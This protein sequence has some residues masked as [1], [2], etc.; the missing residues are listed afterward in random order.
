MTLALVDWLIIISYLILSVAIGLFYTRKAGKNS[1]SFFL[2]GRN[3]PWW[4]AG[5]SMVA[6]TFAA[7]TP[8]AVT[9]LVGKNGISGNWLWWS[10]LTGGMLTVFFFARLWRRANILTEVEFIELR[11]SGKE[12]S[13][14]R[15]FKG[16]Y[17][18]LIMNVVIL[19]WV[20]LAMVKI[21]MVFF[22][23]DKTTALYYTAGLMMF[24]A[25]YSSLS[26]LLGVAMTDV[27]QFIIAMTG[28][29][30]LAVIVVNSDKIGGIEGLKQKLPNDLLGFFPSTKSAE[31]SGTNIPQTFALSIG[32]FLAFF[33]VQW[34]SSWYPGAEPGGGGYVAQR[35]MSTKTEKDSI[36]A[37]LF[38]Q[39]TH[40]CLRPWPWILVGL[41]SLVLYPD[42]SM[43]DKGQ[44]FVMAMKE[45]LP[46][47]LKGFLLVAFLAAYMS[48][49]STQLNWGTSYIVNDVYRRF[50]RKQTSFSSNEKA[51]KHYVK[52]GRIMTMVLMIISL[53]VTT[54]L[55][56]IS[57]AWEFVMECGAGLGGVLIVRWYWWRVNAWSEIAATFSPFIYYTVSKYL[58]HLEYPN[59]FFL[60][61]GCTTLT[62]IIVT[63]MTKP[64]D[65]KHLEE[66]YK[67]I[68]P[69][70]WW[71]P[72]R[73]KANM[74]KT[75]WQLM[76]L[77]V[78][79]LSAV[80]MT[81]CVLFCIGSF[82]FHN[83]LP[84]LYYG[85][86]ALTSFF[87]LKMFVSK[88]K[89]FGD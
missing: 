80:A 45:F 77:V 81:Y 44:G 49:L 62:W 76:N 12:A 75:K 67:R 14:L 47:G 50:Y 82:I 71:E 72:V 41:C 34:W 25:I 7:D 60:T 58:L 78:C 74:Q 52:A 57:R 51:E 9:E 27:V 38:F 23:M 59:G 84:S 48:T 69:G 36:Y 65:E 1:E 70:G 26:G 64:S 13:F 66:F 17:L 21:L 79:W 11:Y 46:T 56:T 39:I 10:F 68:T 32:T 2:G 87:L 15:G 33:G 53:I 35:M 5:T 18:G 16:I 29:I 55:E 63:L 20:N 3:L 40:Y 28:C 83:Y 37:T 19:G 86:A 73:I 43:A 22:G 8:L 88:T 31:S 61:V 85:I 4:I 30:V 54:Q 42:L 89:I 6:T 24:T